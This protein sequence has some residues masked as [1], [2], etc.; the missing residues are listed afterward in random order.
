M[1]QSTLILYIETPLQDAHQDLDF[2]TLEAVVHSLKGTFASKSR[3]GLG[4]N[5]CSK[6]APLRFRVN[7]VGG[8]ISNSKSITFSACR[9][10][11]GLDMTGNMMKN[12]YVCV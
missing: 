3:I 1:K 10:D 2:L 9:N 11:K 6:C 12:M 7:M 8:V 4:E 5:A